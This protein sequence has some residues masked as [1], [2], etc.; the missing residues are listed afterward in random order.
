MPTPLSPILSNDVFSV[1]KER[2]IHWEYAPGHRFT[3]E[4]LCEEFGISRSP[5]REALR[6]LVEN[7]L[8]TKDTA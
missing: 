2:I 6:M 1:L 7:R 3:E 4:A 8:P 5:V